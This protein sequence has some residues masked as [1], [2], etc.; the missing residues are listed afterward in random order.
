MHQ[1][2][3]SKH[4]IA[5]CVALGGLRHRCDPVE[6]ILHSAVLYA[7]ERI[8]E[9]IGDRADG[10]IPDE[11]L[12]ALVENLVDGRDHS[13]RACTERLGDHAAFSALD[14]FINRDGLFLCLIAQVRS[15]L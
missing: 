8:V 13:R 5:S 6:R 7:G 10:V 1:V 9:F 15:K 2:G 4:R 14:H 12:F 11:D 3:F